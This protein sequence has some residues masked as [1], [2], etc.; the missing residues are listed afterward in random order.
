MELTSRASIRIRN[1]ITATIP[2]RLR[3]TNQIASTPGLDLKT[4]VFGYNQ[5][6]MPQATEVAPKQ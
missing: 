2:F 3:L 6:Y 4:S 5:A 1:I